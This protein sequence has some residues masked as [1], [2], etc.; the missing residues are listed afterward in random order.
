[1]AQGEQAYERAYKRANEC[2]YE[3]AY[4]RAYERAYEHRENLENE[5]QVAC[6]SIYFTSNFWVANMNLQ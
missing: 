1:M 3:R 5:N 4:K 2:T 6:I